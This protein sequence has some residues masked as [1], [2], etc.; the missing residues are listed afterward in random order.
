MDKTFVCELASGGGKY[1]PNNTKLIPL[2]RLN[3]NV[4]GVL[5]V[6]YKLKEEV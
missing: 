5:E 3:G 4:V 1:R 6:N 2:K